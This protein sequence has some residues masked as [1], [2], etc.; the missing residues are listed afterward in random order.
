MVVRHLR[1]NLVAYLALLVA[2]SGYRLCGNGESAS[3][4]QRR[5]GASNQRVAQERRPKRGGDCC[6]SRCSRRQRPPRYPGV[7]GAGRRAR[8]TGGAREYGGCKGCRDPR[9]FSRRLTNLRGFHASHRMVRVRRRRSMTPRPAATPELPRAT[10]T[11]ASRSLASEQIISS[12]M[13]HALRRPTR[14]PSSVRASAGPVA[15]ST[16]PAM[17]TGT[18]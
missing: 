12:R 5:L 15:R 2:L 10:A 11:T 18:S 17:T 8:R 7:S 16:P 14:A 13:T 3:E 9:V 1:R 6:A 4:E